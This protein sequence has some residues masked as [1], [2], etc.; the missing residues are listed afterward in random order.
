[1]TIGEIAEKTNLPQSTLRYYEKK[2]LIKV[3]RDQ[4]GRRD[5]EE[6]DIEWIKFI[7]RLKETG[8]LLKDI[9]EYSQLRY[10][11]TGTMPRRLE[12]LQEHR[13]YVVEQQ[14]KWDEYLRNLDDKILFYRESI[15]T[16]R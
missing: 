1:M 6:G 8:M 14:R 10:C 13:K 11:G 7:R 16:D 5:Y 15:E 12:I 2:G 4:S 3:A 9:R